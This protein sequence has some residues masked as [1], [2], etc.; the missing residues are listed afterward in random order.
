MKKEILD[1]DK[2]RGIVRVTT[3][4]ERWYSFPSK[5][6][7]SGLPVYKF[8]P[9]VTWICSYYPK[10][11]AL[12]QWI[13]AKG[14]DDAEVAKQS[15]ADKGSKIHQACE[16]WLGGAKIEMS[17]KFRNHS[18][19]ADEELTVEEY[20]AVMSFV[21]WW[22]LVNPELVKAEFVVFNEEEGYAGTVDILVRIGGKLMLI[23]IK[24][25]QS[26][27][28]EYELQLSAYRRCL[29]EE[30]GQ[31]GMAIL[32]V[33]YKRNGDGFKFTEVGD[34]FQIFQ[35]TKV[36]WKNETEGQKPLQKDYPLVLPMF[37]G[38]LK[39]KAETTVKKS[40]K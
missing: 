28:P 15:A 23:D 2:T 39:G 32:Q 33:G 37:E 11:K 40:S 7:Y 36:V 16:A 19:Q 22:R 21:K 24:S 38:K 26:V 25:G 17:S 3:T 9:S 30:Y 1:V 13:A 10:G 18:K 5:E 27:W 14:W 34:K 29:L 8:I 35:A 31:M 12:T 6:K 4:D 20:E